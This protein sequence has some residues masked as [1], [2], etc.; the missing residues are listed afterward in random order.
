MAFVQRLRRWHRW[1]AIAMSGIVLLSAGSGLVHTWMAR[2]QPPPPPARPAGVVDLAGVAVAPRDLPVPA[3]TSLTL[4]TLEGRPWWQ[5]AT[6]A[7]PRWFDAA[8]GAEDP[9]A[10]ERYAAQVASASLGG[11]AVRQS[12]YLTAYDREYIAIFRILPV[13]R[14]AADDERGTRVYV[15]TVTGSVTRQT[16]DR[17]Q[18]EAD[19]F[20]YAHKWMFIPNRTLRD[21]A[22]MTAMGLIILL[23]AG[24]LVL[25]W[26][27]GRRPGA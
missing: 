16:D 1:H 9:A 10:D 2:T 22:L 7:G 11:A 24:G 21:W 5:V 8:S 23:A 13:Y 4:R 3:A 14:F 18:F 15:S 25:A 26:L 19:L 12:G 6:A 20:S 27:T 17:R